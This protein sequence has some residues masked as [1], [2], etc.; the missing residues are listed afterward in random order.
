MTAEIAS[1]YVSL[2]P[3]FKGGAS[4]I[5]QQLG[6]PVEAA[7]RDAGAKAGKEGS[8]SF[9]SSM[10]SGAA[11]LAGGLA[12][13]G[14]INL[15][16]GAFDLSVQQ[17]NLPGT[18]KNEFGL[19]GPVAK[20]AADA[21]GKLYSEGWGE[22]LSAVGSSVGTVARALSGL[23]TSDDVGKV[24]KQAEGLAKT[25]GEEV[26]SVV[27]AASQLVKTGL[28]PSMSDAMDVIARG[29]QSG[30]NSGKDFLDSVGEYSV[31]F[32]KLGIDA[33]TSIGL[34]NQALAAG[35]RNS[36]FVADAIKEFSVIAVSGSKAATDGFKAVGLDA[37][38]AA[39]DIAKGGPTA[40]ATFTKVLDG[41]RGM[42]DPLKQSQTAVGLFG[43]KAEDLGKSLF[44]L[45]PATA[46]ATGAMSNIGGAADEVANQVGSGLSTQLDSLGRVFSGTLAGAIQ[47][48]LPILKGLLDFIQPIA[49]ILAPIA[50]AI[51]VLTVAQWAWNAAMMANPVGL[52]IALVAGLVIGFIALWNKSAAFRDFFI[53]IWNGIK[54]VV[55]VVADWFVARWNDITSWITNAWNSIGSFFSRLWDGIKSV[56][57]GHVQ[58]LIQRWT[59][60]KSF[61]SGLLDGIKGIFQSVNQWI[62]DRW[63]DLIGFF[64]GIP[65]TFRSIFNTVADAISAPF[66]AAFQ[67]IK[68]LWNSTIGGFGF[69]VPDWV[70]IVG[71]KS[72]NIPMLAAGGVVDRPTLAMIG[73][74]GPEAVVP[75]S[76]LDTMLSTPKAA[77][78]PAVSK[79]NIA[80]EVG[81]AL[82]SWT[83]QIDGKGLAKMVH[84]ADIDNRGR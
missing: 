80:E 48:L 26:P 70:P 25:F 7:G 14:G 18:L 27:E 15:V 74:A 68:N 20:Q 56:V 57:Q 49:P 44:A 35:A 59:D 77:S 54:D 21:A 32:Q 62:R 10:A 78:A 40:Q 73:E 39:A 75:L 33:P 9:G 45:N 46:A 38:Q 61:F 76:K 50:I 47:G 12:I 71:G 63:N 17:A 52:V 4:A 79:G 37:N 53:G 19:V 36:D 8:K 83:V 42:K 41:L 81:N 30:A 24:T 16:K 3:S 11:A 84:K 43:T 58:W 23:G 2:I 60:V 51:G 69:K 6:G 28:A 31:Q 82:R 34:V 1:A 67:G 66:R 72:F 55:G 22:S 65:G 5:S 64:Q 29:F 13:F